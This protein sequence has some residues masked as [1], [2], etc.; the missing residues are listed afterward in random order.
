MFSERHDMSVDVVVVRN[1]HHGAY[2][3]CFKELVAW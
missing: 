1:I 2:E 3:P